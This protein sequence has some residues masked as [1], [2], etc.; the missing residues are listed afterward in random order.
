MQHAIFKTLILH[1]FAF[2]F[3][4]NVGF[5]QKDVIERSVPV[6]QANFIVKVPED[7]LTL[8]KSMI[9]FDNASNKLKLLNKPQSDG[10]FYYFDLGGNNSE[11]IYEGVIDSLGK[12]KFEVTYFNKNPISIVDA[13]KPITIKTYTK[14]TFTI[15]LEVY[16]E[17]ENA[18]KIGKVDL[19]G[20]QKGTKIPITSLE[21]VDSLSLPVPPSKSNIQIKANTTSH[22]AGEYETILHLK[23]QW[24]ETSTQKINLYLKHPL[25]CGLLASIIGLL[26]GLWLKH[27][28]KNEK[29]IV[30]LMKIKK[31]DEIVNDPQYNIPQEKKEEYLTK[32]HTF[33]KEV[34]AWLKTE[35][36]FDAELI[37]LKNELSG[38]ISTNKPEGATFSMDE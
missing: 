37:K 22:L 2:L 5:S 13:D 32:L 30:I 7:G 29:R 15:P 16:N 28:S 9:L 10:K 25:W 14:D 12:V 4:G 6:N 18:I 33:K 8:N 17:S 34:L 3:M 36:Y 38:L 26:I 19:T 31:F 11:G 21:T 24:N 20:F 27:T 35:E 23:N 1:I